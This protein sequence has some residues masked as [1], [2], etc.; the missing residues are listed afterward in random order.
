M[1]GLSKE[2][3]E[4]Y[5]RQIR[6]PGFGIEGQLKLQKAKVLVAGLGGLGSPASIYLAAAGVGKLLLI[7]KEVVELSNLNRQILHWDKD[8]SRRKVD[9]AV[10]KLRQLNPNISIEGLAVQINEDNI[11]DFV[12]EVDLVV[13]GMDNFKTRFIINEACVKLGKPFIHGAVYG[14]EGRLMTIIPRKGPCLRCLIPTEPPEVK[15]F[16]VL[17]ATPA[18]IA[19]LQ[20]IEAIKVLTGI[21]EPLVGKLLV[22]DG[23]PMSFYEVIVKRSPKCPVCS[24]IK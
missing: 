13:D 19:S 15:P 9:S 8:V 22:F 1:D 12:K 18:V 16:P 5:D 14:L 7:D 2:D 24:D 10:E 21:G 23:L 20:V 3:L 4:R 17:G 11:Y 6:I